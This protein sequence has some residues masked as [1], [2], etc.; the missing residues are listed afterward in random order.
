M[1]ADRFACRHTQSP[2]P[3]NGPAYSA[4]PEGVPN[5]GSIPAAQDRVSTRPRNSTESSPGRASGDKATEP[6]PPGCGMCRSLLLW[7][8]SGRCALALQRTQN[9]SVRLLRWG[10]PRMLFGN[11]IDTTRVRDENVCRKS[12][13]LWS[14]E[15]ATLPDLKRRAT[16]S[17]R[18]AEDQSRKMMEDAKL[19][20]PR[21]PHLRFQLHYRRVR[22]FSESV[23]VWDACGRFHRPDC[24][25]GGTAIVL[26]SQQRMLNREVVRAKWLVVD[27]SRGRGVVGAPEI[28]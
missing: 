17:C 20:R 11:G 2:S 14:D 28:S 12:E 4:T 21:R 15:R 1:P 13:S 22:S 8:R 16:T 10:V 24:N 5:S 18:F 6:D 19:Y 3:A 7:E 26:N 27:A 9:K 23:L 25:G